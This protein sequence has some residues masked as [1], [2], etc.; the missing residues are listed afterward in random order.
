MKWRNSPRSAASADSSL[1]RMGRS[2]GLALAI[3]HAYALARDLGDVAFL[4]EHE[5]ARDGQQRRHVGGDEVLAD[6]DAEHDRAAGAR[7]DDAV[8][9]LARQHGE[10]IGAIELG[11]GGAARP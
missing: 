9:V 4:Q 7:D 2:T 11:D 6:A 1:S 5:L 10:R 8:G 3:E